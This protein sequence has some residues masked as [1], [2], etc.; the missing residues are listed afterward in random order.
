ME[1]IVLHT[2]LRNRRMMKND[3]SN[4]PYGVEVDFSLIASQVQ[5][6]AQNE[7]NSIR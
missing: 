1:R 5:A 3:P 6:V 7:T 4:L 2:T